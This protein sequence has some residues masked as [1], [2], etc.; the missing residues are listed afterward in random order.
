MG[1]I[2]HHEVEQGLIGDGIR[3]VIMGKFGMG[4]VICPR[5]GVVPTE[6]LEVHFNFLVYL[7]GFSIQLRVVGG[8]KG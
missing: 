4:D 5:S 6:D 2:T 8:G 3:A 1:F 7:F